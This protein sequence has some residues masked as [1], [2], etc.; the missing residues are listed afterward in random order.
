MP[1]EMKGVVDGMTRGEFLKLALCS[2]SF[3]AL[4]PFRA[5]AGM[6]LSGRPNLVLGIISDIHV[7]MSRKDGQTVFNGEAVLRRTFEWFKSRGVDAVAI[8]GDMADFGLVEELEAVGR[9]WNDTFGGTKVEK[10][11]VYGNHDWEA[12]KYGSHAKKLF[13]AEKTVFRILSDSHRRKGSEERNL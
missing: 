12:Y 10:L 2:G 7:S 6:R 13:D 1:S 9:A 8:C 4:H 5:F 3:A 11:F